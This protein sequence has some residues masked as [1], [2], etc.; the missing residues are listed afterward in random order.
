MQQL[1]IIVMSQFLSPRTR[2]EAIITETPTHHP[3]THHQKLFKD[4]VL[5]YSLRETPRDSQRLP[6]T[7]RDS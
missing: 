2:A 7:P 5:D 1:I 3:P 4:H 6:E